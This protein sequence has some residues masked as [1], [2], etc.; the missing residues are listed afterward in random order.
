M[1]VIMTNGF[2]Q[3]SCCHQCQR[4][5][6]SENWLRLMDNWYVLL[7]VIDAN[8]WRVILYID[9]NPWIILVANSGS[10]KTW[11]RESSLFEV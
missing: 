1:N 11:V 8:H 4:G 9:V 7:V 10:T 2:H 5:I 6:L 3:C